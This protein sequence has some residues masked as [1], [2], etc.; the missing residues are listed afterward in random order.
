MATFME[1]IP[2]PKSIDE[3]KVLVVDN[4]GL[5]HDLVNSALTDLG[6]KKVS[7]AQNA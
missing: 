2:L 6:V 1:K 7:S 3:L 4:Q 5:I